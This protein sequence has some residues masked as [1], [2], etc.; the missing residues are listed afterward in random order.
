MKPYTT[1]I[2][3]VKIQL[4]FNNQEQQHA[5]HKD[6]VDYISK[7]YFVNYKDFANE[8][9]RQINRVYF[10]YYKNTYIASIS[11][12]IYTRLDRKNRPICIYYISIKQAGLQRYNK[13]IDNASS[14]CLFRLCAFANSNDLIFKITQLDIAIDIYAKFNNVLAVCTKRTPNT[15]YFSLSEQQVFEQTRYVENIAYHRR[16]KVSKHAYTYDKAYKEGLDYDLTRFE[17]SLN[18]KFFSKNVLSID[19][20]AK[21]LD[22]YHVMYFPTIREKQTKITEYE[23]YAKFRSRDVKRIGFESYRLYPDLMYINEFLYWMFNIELFH[24][25]EDLMNDR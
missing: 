13:D 5:I 2:D 3:T 9:S 16:Y 19:T 17:L 21:A 6:I 8:I 18:P 7:H 12:G 22:R 25:E 10:V 20:I 11:T 23:R 14:D 24:F 4:D 1:E 15:Q